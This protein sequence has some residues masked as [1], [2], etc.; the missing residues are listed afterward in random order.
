[1]AYELLLRRS[2][3]SKTMKI[4][5]NLKAGATFNPFSIT[6]TVDKSSPL[7]F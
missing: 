4:K 3:R 7:F 5:T 1:M 2:E 6:K